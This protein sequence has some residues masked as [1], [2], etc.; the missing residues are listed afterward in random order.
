MLK[1]RIINRSKHPLPSYATPGSAGMDLRA[2]IDEPR[3][4]QPMER[5]LIPTGIHIQ[6][7]IGFEGQIRPRSGL[8]AKKGITLVNGV[9]TID[10]D[11]TGE[12]QLAVINLSQEPY[13]IQ[14]GERLAQ[15]VIA[16]YERIEWMPVDQLMS[17][18]RG[19]GGF[20]STGLQ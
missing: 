18:T 13:T 11:Y 14:D 16:R 4:L 3:T 12:I 9:G 10:C 2:N 17:T 15:L 5:A 8:S 20:G 6:L 1:V 19:Q 7:P